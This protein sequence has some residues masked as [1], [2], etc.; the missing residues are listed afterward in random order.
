MLF[1]RSSEDAVAPL[2]RA[3]SK[4][5]AVLLCA[6]LGSA[7]VDTER[8]QD[9]GVRLKDAQG[10]GDASEIPDMGSDLDGGTE[11]QGVDAGPPPL[12]SDGDGIPDVEDPAPDRDNPTL[13]RDVFDGAVQTWVFSSVSMSIDEFT[14]VL[15]VNVLEP[16]VREGWIG[17]KPE[18]SDFYVR[19]RIRVLT[20]GGSS[21]EASGRTGVIA[22]VNQVSPDRY[23]FCSI[24]MKTN[25]V[26]LTEHEGGG[27]EGAV[28]ARAPITAAFGAWLPL[29]IRI[30]SQGVI[31]E[32]GGVRVEANQNAVQNGSVGF[33]SFDATFEAD[34]L[35]VYDLI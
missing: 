9:G 5:T 15:R 21:E 25:E 31:C 26:V 3:S 20:V 29:T 17:P 10:S 13:F 14:S 28:L 16:F 22:R 27:P 23:L 32:I 12:D 19:S 8:T 18:W 35:E 34:Y 6:L 2:L 1:H 11:D 30:A 33:R 24:D 7:C 4:K